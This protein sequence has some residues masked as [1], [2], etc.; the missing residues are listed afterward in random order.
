MFVVWDAQSSVLNVLD[1]DMECARALLAGPEIRI[2]APEH[3]NQRHQVT[4]H[5]VTFLLRLL[6]Y[7]QYVVGALYILI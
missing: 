1:E 6:K 3:D 4:N 7:Q 5:C 2:M